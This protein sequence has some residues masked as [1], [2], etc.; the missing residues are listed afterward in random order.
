[1]IAKLFNFI[2]SHPSDVVLTLTVIILT[3]SSYNLG[4]IMA[5][6]SLKTPITIYDT[7]NSQNITQPNRERG[8]QAQIIPAPKDPTV[9]ASKNSKSKLYHFTWCPGASQIADKNKLTFATE[10]A[11]IAAGYTLAGNCQK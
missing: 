10:S 11:A 4:K 6:K 1:M 2:K 5:Y 8:N 3:I 7:Q 9:I